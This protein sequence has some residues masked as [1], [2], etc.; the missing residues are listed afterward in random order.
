MRY[1]H[2]V[3][4]L[5]CLALSHVLHAAG[6]AQ[7]GQAKSA[8]CAAC[9]GIDGN[10]TNPVWPKLAGQSAKYTYTHLMHYKKNERVHVLMNPQAAGLSEQDMHDLAAY[11]AEQTVAPANADEALVEAGELLYRGGNKETNTP[12]CIACHGPGGAGNPAAGY[13]MLSHQHAPY[14]EA[15]LKQYRAAEVSYTNSEI[16]VAVSSRL[17]DKEIKAVASYIQGLHS[18]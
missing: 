8:V 17:S 2:F 6:D 7:Q 10:S 9:H 18:R 16:M 15:R 13:P 5:A 14:I 11:Y 12:A 4:L 1:F 3:M